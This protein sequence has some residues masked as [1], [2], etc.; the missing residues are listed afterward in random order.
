MINTDCEIKM[1]FNL[2]ISVYTLV[3]RA[4]II[5]LNCKG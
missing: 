1:F 3:I 5:W 4:E 2:F